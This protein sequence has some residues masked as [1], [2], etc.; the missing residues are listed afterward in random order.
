MTLYKSK[1]RMESARKRNH[2]YGSQ[3]KYFVTI[4]TKKKL[5]W[6]GEI[7]NG[8]MRLSE[9]GESAKG[10]I[11][12]IP[13]H[14]PHATVLSFVI[15]PDH[16][17]MIVSIE[18]A[19]VETQNF[20]SLHEGKFGPQSRNLGSIIRG[21]KIGVTKESKRLDL[22]F[23]WQSRFH[24]HIIKSEKELTAIKKYITSNSEKW[25]KET[26]PW[27]DDAVSWSL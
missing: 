20:A 6:F 13:E 7:N 9:I 10:C 14:F 27:H 18:A 5:Q 17:H 4:C 26:I 15:M 1:Y 23:Q 3:G 19:S 2:D 24:D 22:P 11:D 12:T 25:D 8:K 16:V 21:F